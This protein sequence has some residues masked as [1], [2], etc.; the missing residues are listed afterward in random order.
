MVEN[1]KIV[2]V[3]CENLVSMPLALMKLPA[4]LFVSVVFVYYVLCFL[5][6]CGSYVNIISILES[7]HSLIIQK[8]VNAEALLSKFGCACYIYA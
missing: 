7:S 2:Y 5:D 4:L 6:L 3:S 1:S 8:G